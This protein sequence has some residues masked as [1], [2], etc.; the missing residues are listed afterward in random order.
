MVG[1][2]SLIDQKRPVHILTEILKKGTIPQALLFTGM[3]GVG[4]RTAAMAFAMV[5]NCTERPKSSLHDSNPTSSSSAP[6]IDSLV[7]SDPCGVCRP[8]RKIETHSHPDYIEIAPTGATIR[9]N[10]VRNLLQTLSMKPYEAGFRVVV[11]QDAHTMNPE[12][13]NA[14][15]K[16]LEEPPFQTVFILT[17]TARA[18]LL[19][20]IV[21]RCQHIRFNPMATTTIATILTRDHNIASSRAKALAALADGSLA[22]ALQLI[23]ERWIEKRNWLVEAG[24]LFSNASG[25]HDWV[26][27]IIMLANELSTKRELATVALDLLKSV[28]RDILV[29]RFRP[30]NLVN[31]D[32]SD[33]ISDAAGNSTEHDILGKIAAIEI[34][35]KQIHENANARLAL[36]SLFL[37]LAKTSEMN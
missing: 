37:T 3:T 4:K 25:Q 22:A 32:I 17:A 8:C 24:G 30:G 14:L 27:K 33:F 26:A 7:T 19:P 6:H 34:A 13:G 11:I 20:T 15:L 12:S 18:D 29:S 31:S 2:S 23:K 28:Y 21:S 35:Q 10:Q 36:E 5:L 9:V 16:V 1:F